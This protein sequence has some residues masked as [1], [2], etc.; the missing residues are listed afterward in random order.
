MSVT[1]ED[2]PNGTNNDGVTEVTFTKANFLTF[3]EGLHFGVRDFTTTVLVRNLT[4]TKMDVTFFLSTL[5]P[6]EYPESLGK[7]SIAISTSLKVK[8]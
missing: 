2:Y 1:N 8:P 4:A 3:S 6:E 7:P 5:N